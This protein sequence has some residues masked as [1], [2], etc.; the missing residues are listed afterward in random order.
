MVLGMSNTDANRT[1]S[2]SYYLQ[3][4]CPDDL[5]RRLDQARRAQ[6][7]PPTRPE[8]VRAILDQ[9]L[10]AEVTPKARPSIDNRPQD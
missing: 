2:K 5:L 9:A 4:S 8:M 3:V 1:S 10:P 7:N 6:A